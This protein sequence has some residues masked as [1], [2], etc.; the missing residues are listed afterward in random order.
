M[1]QTHAGLDGGEPG[2]KTLEGNKRMMQQASSGGPKTAQKVS[3]SKAEKKPVPR[4]K[5]DF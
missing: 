4:T 3:N 2:N 1:A 5:P